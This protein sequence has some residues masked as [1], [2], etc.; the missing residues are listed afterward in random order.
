MI[1][2]YSILGFFL[3]ALIMLQV[4][5]QSPAWPAGNCER[6][7]GHLGFTKW[8][9]KPIPDINAPPEGVGASGGF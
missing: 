8:S 4:E 3:Q 7:E 1:E 9:P 5:Y 6:S 2:I